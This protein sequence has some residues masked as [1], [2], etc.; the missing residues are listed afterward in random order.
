MQGTFAKAAADDPEF[1]G[2]EAIFLKNAVYD[3]NL[4]AYQEGFGT[5]FLT[6]LGFTIPAILNDYVPAEG[7]QALIP[8][9]KIEVLNTAEYLIWGIEKDE[10]KV[11][12]ERCQVSASS[13]R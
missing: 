1:A 13:P 10:D 12:L 7:G 5:E 3:G 4:I 11:E 9:E 6:N 8:T 2:R